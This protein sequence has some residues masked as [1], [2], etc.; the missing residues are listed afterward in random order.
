MHATTSAG[1]VRGI[2]RIPGD[3]R[4][5]LRSGLLLSRLIRGSPYAGYLTSSGVPWWGLGTADRGFSLRTRR[6]C[7]K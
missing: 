2:L 3:E 7:A 1:A 6:H 5:S 4:G